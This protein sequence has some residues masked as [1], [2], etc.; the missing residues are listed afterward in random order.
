MYGYSSRQKSSFSN[1]SMTDTIHYRGWWKHFAQRG[2]PNTPWQ[3][4]MSTSS[5]LAIARC[6]LGTIRYAPGWAWA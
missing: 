1:H 4:S 6:S 3:L 5:P 2:I